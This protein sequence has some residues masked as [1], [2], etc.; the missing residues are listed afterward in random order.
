MMPIAATREYHGRWICTG[1]G[2]CNRSLTALHEYLH[3]VCSPS[4]VH[5]NIKSANILLDSELSPHLSDSGLASLATDADQG[6]DDNGYSAPE[7]SMSA[8]GREQNSLWFGGLH[9]SFMT[10]TLS[11]RWLIQLLKDYILS[12]LSRYADVI[13]LCVQAEPEFRSSMSKVVQAL[14]RLVQRANM[15]K[16]TAGIEQGSSLRSGNQ[17][18]Q[19]FM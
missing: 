8:Q 6:L 11:Q 2:F 19:E 10:W 3:E 18:S 12:N 7:V 14:V 15:S 4:V 16:R 13:T 5:K 1:Y 17:D 9:L